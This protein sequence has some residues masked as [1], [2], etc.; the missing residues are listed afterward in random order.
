VNSFSRLVPFAWPYRWKLGL[1]V[2]F[3]L[4]AALLWG[5]NLS[6]AFPIVKVL[7][8]GQT[9]AAYV[10][11]EIAV[12][13]NEIQERTQALRVLEKADPGVDTLKDQA[14]QQN[15]LSAASRKLLM[16]KWVKSSI[17]PWI[18][19]DQFDTF[20]LILVLLLIATALK[21][22]LVFVQEVLIGSVVHLTVIGLRKHC[23]RKILK[24]DY[25]TLALNG[26]PDLMS[27]FTNDMNVLATGLW[28]LGGKVV[29]EPLKALMCVVLAL[30]VNWRLTLLSFVFAPL[31]ALVFYRLGKSLKRASHRLMENMSRLYKT[32]EETFDALKVVIAFNA[33]RRHRRRFHIENKEYYKKS[34]KLVK[35]DALTS[36]STEVLGMLAVFVVLLPGAYLVLRGT[37]AIWGIQLSADVMDIAELSLLYAMLAGVIDPIRKLSTVYAKLKRAGAAADRIFE[38]VDRQPLVKEPET[39]RKFVRHHESVEFSGIEFTYARNDSHGSHRPAALEDVSVTVRAGEVVAVVGE[40][41]SGKSTLVNLLPRYYD[42]DQGEVLI[43]GIDIRDIRLRDLRSQ[44]SIVTQ[45]TLLFDET[46]YENIRYGRPE[47]TEAEICEAARQ[48]HVMQ[49][50]DQLPDGLQT[51]VGEKGQRLSGGQRQRVALARAMLRDPAILILDEATSAIDSHSEFLI[52]EA[53]RKFV[54]G[55]TTFLITH[56]VSQSILDFVTQIIVMDRGGLIAAGPHA[57][58]IESCPIYQRLYQAQVRQRSA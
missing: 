10:D 41:G 15:K 30:C 58:L 3:A 5:A 53:L 6:V 46:I 35:L 16:M 7:L 12:A 1:S 51:T 26:T 20:S 52:H 36:P 2:V 48:A 45:E 4:L 54:Q 11:Q 55:R 25:Q 24:L 8:Q 50:A 37:N 43:D 32:M 23:F 33:G 17:I 29:R 31:T 38:L 39:P 9:L 42:P 14:R 28:L 21:V 27:R 47:A 18:P 34:M 56:S 13:E 40:N 22:S 44:L 19:R 49:F 57:S